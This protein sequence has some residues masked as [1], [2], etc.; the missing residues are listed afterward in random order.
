MCQNGGVCDDGPEGSGECK[1]GPTAT[2]YECEE[3]VP[4]YDISTQCTTKTCAAGSGYFGAECTKCPACANFGTCK[5]GPSGDGTCSGPPNTGGALCERCEADF[6]LGSNCTT[7]CPKG[8]GRYGDDCLPCNECLNLGQCNDGPTGDGSCVCPPNT[9][10]ADC[11]ACATN[12]DPSTK[13][14]TL[15]DPCVSYVS[16]S[17]FQESS[18]SRFCKQHPLGECET[19]FTTVPAAVRCGC[20]A[21][22]LR[23]AETDACVDE[24]E[25]KAKISP[26]IDVANAACTNFVGG[27]NCTCKKGYVAS[28]VDTLGIT[29]T[30][31]RLPGT[32]A[33]PRKKSTAPP[34]SAGLPFF[35]RF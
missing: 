18:F 10:N 14:S 11:S 17:N 19:D 25:C 31:S 23:S 6:D 4:P 26:C 9:L 33:P 28:E 24:N 13:C 3:C 20:I 1:C 29:R 21:G 12:Y 32:R 8:S 16:D 34:K 15:L 22:Y 5:D 30:C 7:R 27:Y 2:G 35:K